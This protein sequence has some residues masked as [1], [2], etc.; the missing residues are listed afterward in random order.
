MRIETGTDMRKEWGGVE[1]CV[2]SD[3][4]ESGGNERQEMN[5]WKIIRNTKTDK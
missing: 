3:E 4:K 2:Y 1:M 5:E